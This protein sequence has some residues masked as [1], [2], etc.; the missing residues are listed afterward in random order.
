MRYG[1]A[2]KRCL[3]PSS[4]SAICPLAQGVGFQTP[5]LGKAMR[6][7]TSSLTAGALSL[8]ALGLLACAAS[9][10]APVLTTL[11][12]FPPDIS[13]VTSRARQSFIVKATFADGIT[14]DVTAEAKVSLSNPALVRLDKN[15]IY[16]VAD[17]S[18]ELK[19]DFGGKTAA[20]PVKITNAKADRPIS[21][22]VDVMPGFMR[23][24][25]NVGGCHGAAR[26]KD[27]FRL[28]LFGYD[29]EG[30]HYRLTR[31]INGRRINLALPHESLI[32]EKAT[33]RVNHTGGTRFTQDS[34]LYQT[35]IRWLEAGAP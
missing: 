32:L 27:G 3:E 24:G 33:G 7:A 9:A 1:F 2:Q 5:F 14:R 12:V 26:G 18:T 28:S 15:V 21:F 13:M 4:W 6:N 25:C 16:P 29:P 17:G 22:K 31:E 23:A 30:D 35:L 20:A 8:V 11:E 34:E 19:A 10:Q